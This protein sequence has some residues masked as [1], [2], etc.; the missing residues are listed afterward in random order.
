MDKKIKDLLQLVGTPYKA[1]FEDGTYCGCFEPAYFLY[2]E[3][4]RCKLPS[5]DKSE[6]FSYSFNIIDK[7]MTRIDNPQMGDVVITRF[8]NQLHCGIYY[9]YGKMI[10]VLKDRTLSIDKI[11]NFNQRF[12]RYYKVGK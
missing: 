6:Y 8:A 5:D 10:H 3:L 2:P 4:P 1:E 7:M 12:L 11:E 9:Q